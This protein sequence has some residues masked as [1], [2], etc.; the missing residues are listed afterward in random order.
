M[1]IAVC[2]KRVP[3]MEARFRIAGDGTSV[4]QAGLKFDFSD[5]DAYAVEVALQLKEKAGRGEIVA[6]SLG[7]DVVQETLR[8]AMSLGVDR[9]VQLK[10]DTVPFDGF[11]IARA[12]AAELKVADTSSSCSGRCP[13]TRRTASWAPWWRSSLIFHS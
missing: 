2:V 8:K 12:L 13:S 7:P 11:A 9:A 4:D 5:F 1:K 10:S 6:I 3:D